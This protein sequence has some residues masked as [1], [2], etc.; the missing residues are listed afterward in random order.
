VSPLRGGVLGA[1]LEASGPSSVSDQ[2]NE[3][4][5]PKTRLLMPDQRACAAQAGANA[6]RLSAARHGA[7]IHGTLVPR[8]LRMSLLGFRSRFLHALV[9]ALGAGCALLEPAPLPPR[10]ETLLVVDT[11][12]PVPLVVSRLR[13]DVSTED[14]RWIAT[15]D[16]VRADPRDWPTSFSVYADDEARP[17]T[18]V[19]RLRAYLD[20]RLVPYAGP[21]KL[22]GAETPDTEPDPT[23][24]VERTV[25]VALVFGQRGRLVVQLPGACLGKAVCTAPEPV[26]EATMDRA[27]PSRV[28]TFGREPCDGAV[29]ADGRACV[30]G[31]SFVF[32]DRFHRPT[33]TNGRA[34]VDA[35][36]E[37]VVRVSRFAMDAREV[38]VARFRAA[39]SRGFVAKT[40]PFSNERDG[41]EVLATSQEP[42]GA[43]T[44]SATPRGREAYALSCVGWDTA[45]AFC[46]FEGGDL[47]TEAQFEYAALAAGRRAKTLYTWG[48]EPPTC[49]RAIFGRGLG[50]DTCIP[51]GRGPIPATSETEDVTPAGVRDM[52]GSLTELVRD[53]HERFDAS[54]WTGTPERDPWCEVPR[55][56]SCAADPDSLECRYGAGAPGIRKTVRG[57]SWFDTDAELRIVQRDHAVPLTRKVDTFEIVGFRCVYPVAV[58]GTP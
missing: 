52:V 44:W 3:Q 15:R 8:A 47:P 46:R 18:L 55:P 35:R 13:I 6:K 2:K 39:L 40:A 20:A 11:D 24:T 22:E 50:G 16:D 53:D 31:G 17:R 33:S 28:G 14:G 49:A 41:A 57:A 37:R 32:G 23:V 45:R 27:V 12:L 58:S 43:C 10:G 29:V 21:A 36:P 19:V 54:C 25:R 56:P 34:P 51:L 38:T 1:R 5:T 9:L 4:S 30:P 26:L 7:A 42:G 48:D